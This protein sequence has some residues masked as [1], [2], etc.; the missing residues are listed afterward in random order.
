MRKPHQGIRRWLPP[1]C[2]FVAAAFPAGAQT[3][4]RISEFQ[5]LNDSGITD[6]D[7][8]LQGWIEI[9]NTSLTAKVTMTNLR[10]TDGVNAWSFPAVEI[11][12]RDYMLV[13]ASGKDRKVV[14]APLHTSFTIPP[15]GGTL[16]LTNAAGTTT[17]ASLTYPEQAPDVSWGRDEADPAAAATLTGVYTV[18]TPGD[19]NN[20]LGAGVAGAVTISEPSRAYTGTLSVTLAQ[21][22]PEADA[23]IR[24]TLDGTLPGAAS[25]VYTEGAPLTVSTTQQVRARVFRPNFLPGA[26]EARCYL[27]LL[28]NAASFSSSM[29]LMALTN[30]VK[31]A[32]PTDTDQPAYLWVWEPGGVDNRSR[33]TDAPTLVSRVVIDIRGSSTSGNAKYNLNLETRGD[34]NDE[35]RDVNLL[36]MPA[37]SDWVMHA[38][39]DFDRSLLH[40]PF[41]YALSN[42]IGR[43]AVRTRMAE[44]FVDVTASGLSFAG[45]ASG[46]YFG[47][48][49]VMEKIRRGKDRVNI[50]KLD[51]YDNNEVSKTGGFIW[52]VDRL[53]PGDSGFSAAG[54][55]MAYY[56][57]KEIDVKTPQRDPQ[58]KALTAYINS[59]GT[60]LNGAN[61]TNPET[62]YAKWLDVPAALDHHLLNVWSFNV[63]G[64]RLSGYW[65][66]ERGGKMVAGPIWDFDRALSSTDGRDANPATWQSTVP[67]FGTDFFN[68]TW[69]NRLF[70]DANFYQKYID[71]WQSLRRALFSPAAINSLLDNLN[72][73]ISAEAVAR[74]VT[75]WGKTKRN[76]T[77]PFGAGNFTGQTA[78]VQR[79]KDYLQQRANFMDSQWL[80]TVT[81]SPASGRVAAGTQVTLSGPANATIYYTLDG[82]DPR[83]FGGT[84]PVAGYRVYTGPFTINATTRIIARANNP[85]FTARTGANNPPLISKWGG[86]ADVRYSLDPVPAA[87]QV[88]ITEINYN[89]VNPTAAELAV[90]PVWE[91]KDF[92]FLELR[93]VSAVTVDLGG[94]E[95]SSGVLFPFTGT[96]AVSLAPGQFVVIASNP[97]AFAARYGAAVT[98]LGPWSGDLSNGGETVTLSAPN[99][100]GVIASVSYDDDWVP[101]SDGGGATLAL[102]DAAAPSFNTAAAWVAGAAGGSPGA[103]DAAAVA[104]PSAGP[105]VSG[106]VSGTPLAGTVI[107]TPVSGGVTAWSQV[108]GPGTVAFTPAD[109]AG[110][111]AVF[112]QPG[113][114]T[115][116]LSF[117]LAGVTRTDD[118]VVTAGDTPEAWLARHAGIGSLTDDPDQDGRTNFMEFALG[119]DPRVADPSWP[120][121]TAVDNR[122]S[123]FTFTRLKLPSPVSYGLEISSDLATWRAPNAGE[124][125][126]QILADD[127]TAQQV[128]LTDTVLTGTAGQPRRFLRLKMASIP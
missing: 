4:L 122:R 118:T 75:R 26:T 31:G 116:R 9:R 48:Y 114:Y 8:S 67:D 106:L 7:N 109:S 20:Y 71:R 126:E 64:L 58:E 36:G 108:S 14:T 95:L 79:I 52:K 41:I 5:A 85:A 80:P 57:P 43:Y 93:N 127:G 39:F 107:G 72:S 125:L 59:F 94:S 69:W 27:N 30:F 70:R 117:T 44:V 110:S 21:A 61:Y 113:V 60:A 18:P 104:S 54:Q 38:P 47:V 12:P 66:K 19:P 81:A 37:H 103:W 24:Y 82:T 99:G 10:L 123:S 74:D 105:D 62:G 121:V 13:W 92:E 6:E 33:F 63:D 90:N 25:P 16:S 112:S 40:N 101:T 11:P 1:L 22:A 91:A 78:E 51:P 32:P 35:E 96:A 119:T 34:F 88:I 15:A 124:V 77:S 76:W 87:G 2:L 73:Q 3:T 98:P 84:S 111:V 45:N 46:D 49:N 42:N 128:K 68:Y 56:Y 53:D 55:T 23:V 29:P 86:P 17:L 83:P 115:L 89:P 50:K 120:P 102:K 97:A 28:A 100:G 65:H